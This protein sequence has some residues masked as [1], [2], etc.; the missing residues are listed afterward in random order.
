[1]GHRPKESNMTP[2]E[3]NIF[4]EFTECPLAPLE[5]VPTYEYM[6]NLNVY[7]NLCSSAVNCALGCGA[8]GYLVLS[9]Q[10]ALFNTHYGTAFI[11]PTNPVI[12]LVMP[13]PAPTVAV[14]YKLVR[15]YKHGVLLFN[16]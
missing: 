12:H 7:L 6:T 13:D 11:P 4:G 15:T 14:F 5:V 9:A 16:K 3:D 1:M 8:L 2:K 10:T